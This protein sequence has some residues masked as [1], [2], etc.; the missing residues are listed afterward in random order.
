MPEHQITRFLRLLQPEGWTYEEVHPESASERWWRAYFNSPRRKLA[1]DLA[2]GGDCVSF[3]LD[4]L[5]IRQDAACRPAL[6]RYLLRVNH[7]IKL[8]KLTLDAEGR[9]FLA[10]ALPLAALG[11]PAF[12]EILAALA[13]YF[14]HYHREIELVASNR[15]LAGA[16]QPFPPPADPSNVTFPEPAVTA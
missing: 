12:K 9:V 14:E 11:F 15:D 7:E 3:D 10:A 8:A 16:W 6:W 4:L 1:I 5:I 13:A 2:A